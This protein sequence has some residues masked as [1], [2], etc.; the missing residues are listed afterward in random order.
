MSQSKRGWIVVL[1]GLG[2]N[3][4]L[5]ILYTWS[6]F[7]KEF[8][9]NYGWSTFN[10]SIPYALACAMFAA[11]MWPGGKMQD[12]IGARITATLGGALCG[13]GLII[14]SFAPTPTLVTIGFGLITGSG[15]GLAYAAATP[16]AI[17]WFPLSMK[18]LIS[19]IVVTGFGGAPIYASPLANYM[20]TTFGIQQS[21]LYLGIGFMIVSVLLAQLL[22]P[23]P[24]TAGAKTAGAS[25]TAPPVLQFSPGEVFKTP[26]FFYLWLIFVCAAVS[27][28]MIIGHAANILSSLSGANWG[29]VLVAVLAAA[30]AGGRLIAGGVSDKIGRMQTLRITLGLSAI[31]LVALNF[32]NSPYAVAIALVILGF[33]YGSTLAVMPSAT[34]DFYGTKNLGTNYGII[35]TGWGIGGVFGPMLA[36]VI[37]DSTGTYATAFIIAAVLSVV[38][39]GLTTITKMPKA[40]Q[41]YMQRAITAPKRRPAAARAR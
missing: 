24:E 33:D 30:N 5:G 35:F 13:G 7:S 11:L 16:V 31:I 20:L 25:A 32:I 29:F 10:A 23:P 22:V 26:Q 17:K 40:Q 9:A 19:G 2:V 3:L 37:K 6:V 38:G 15:I 14:A 41:E 21:F 8:I 28:L 4:T 27:G 18:G 12:K 34:A 39:V 1:A 36:G